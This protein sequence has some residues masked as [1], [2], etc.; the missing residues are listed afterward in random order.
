MS[1]WPSPA[2]WGRQ[3]LYLFSD[4]GDLFVAKG[5]RLQRLRTADGT[6]PTIRLQVE[7][8]GGMDKSNGNLYFALGEL[9]IYPITSYKEAPYTEKDGLITDASQL[10]SNAIEPT[11]GSLAALIDN[12]LTTYFHSTCT[13]NNATGAK[14]YLQVDLN[15]AYKQIALKY[16]RRQLNA[17]DGTPA[18]TLRVYDLNARRINVNHVDELPQG[19]Y[20]INGKKV[21]R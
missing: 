7:K 3:G 10:S 15:D 13:Q 5:G 18:A 20:V 19:I 21:I 12:N 8:T 1:S 2:A 11:E 4:R 16:S 6:L 14:H 17:D 9:A